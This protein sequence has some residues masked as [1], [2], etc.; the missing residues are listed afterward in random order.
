MP[1]LDYSRLVSLYDAMVTDRGDLDFFLE[2]A[3]VAAG[4]VAELMAGT[5]RLA[6]P[7]ADA[8]IDMTCVDSSP[9]MLQLLEE[10]LVA[11]GLRAK[12]VCDDVTLMNIE[13]R[14]SLV[15]IAFHSFEELVE[16]ADQRA[17][18][19]TVRRHLGANG[20][21]ICTLHDIRARLATV[22]PGKGG[23][24]QFS[25][26]RSQR[27]IAVSLETEYD[28]K[29]GIVRG[30]EAF[31][32]VGDAAPFL[33]V[34]L[35]FRLVKPDAFR[36]IAEDA[37]FVIESV[38]ADFTAREYREGQARTAVWTLRPLNGREHE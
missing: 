1:A 3:R 7:L 34:P 15:F 2:A 9:E 22:G 33:E 13:D 5:G 10:K 25:D 11:K 26:P 28:G 23:R 12:V 24:W 14:F 21:F 29:T 17:C 6:V 37:G 4:P 36:Q 20:R 31:T 27:Q 18:L 30:L 19:D 8:G 38:G 16:D 32:Y 35:R